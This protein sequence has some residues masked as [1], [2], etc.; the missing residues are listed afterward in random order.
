MK[1]SAQE[2]FGIRCLLAIAKLPEGQ[3]MTIEQISFAEGIT[4]PNVSKVLRP[5]RNGGFI[6]SVRGKKGGYILAKSPSQIR[7]DDVLRCLGGRIYDD[8]FCIRHA[9]GARNECVRVSADSCGVRELWKRV[10]MAVDSVVSSVTLQDLLES[11]GEQEL[12]RLHVP[13]EN[14]Y[15]ERKNA[16]RK[17]E[18]AR[19]FSHRV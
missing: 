16:E 9:G 2:E 17:N 13:E 14:R 5:L 12:I 4:Y 11:P 19:S 7:M 6:E 15:R 8:K 18:R 10:Q 3:T 1:L